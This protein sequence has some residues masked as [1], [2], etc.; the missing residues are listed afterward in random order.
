M[1]SDLT[2]I[3]EAPVS[4]ELQQHDT[5]DEEEDNICSQIREKYDDAAESTSAMRYRWENNNLTAQGKSVIG[6]VKLANQVLRIESGGD[7]RARHSY[8]N[9]TRPLIRAFTGKMIRSV[10]TYDFKPR[11]NDQ[12]DMQAS[13]I[14]KSFWDYFWDK[15]KVKVKYKRC[16]ENIPTNGTAV[17]HPYWDPDAGEDILVCDVCGY[18]HEEIDGGDPPPDM[19][20]IECPL[21][22]MKAEMMQQSQEAAGQMHPMAQQPMQEEMPEIGTLQVL[23][24]GDLR[25]L[26]HDVEDFYPDPGAEEIEPCQWIIIRSSEAVN[27][28]RTK[29]PDKAHLIEAEDDMYTDR[30]IYA[31]DGLVNG[32]VRSQRLINHVLVF[33][34]H[35]MP[36]FAYPDGRVIV[37]CNERILHISDNPIA[38]KIGRLP[39]FL[40]RGDR[41][42]KSLWGEPILDQ[43]EGT[44]REREELTT[45][46]RRAR[47]SAVSPQYVTDATSGITAGTVTNKPDAIIKVTRSGDL[48]PIKKQ[49][50]PA[51][52]PNELIRLKEAA[53]EKF[54]VTA[55]EIGAVTGDMSGRSMAFLETQ[56]SE[57][58]APLLLEINSEMLELCKTV[59]CMAQYYMDPDKIWTIKGRSQVL[60][61][62][63]GEANIKPGWDVHIAEQD[64]L[65]RNPTIRKQEAME[66]LN[67][68]NYIDR[69]TGMPDMEGFRRDAG[70]K[71]NG[72]RADADE[73][74]RIYASQFPK[75]IE[76]AMRGE[77]EMPVPKPWDNAIIFAEELYD[78][79]QTTGVSASD[80]LQATVFQMWTVYMQA[81]IETGIMAPSVAGMMPNMQLAQQGQQGQ[82]QSMG[83][84]GSEPQQQGVT[85]QTAQSVQQADNMAENQIRKA[86]PHEG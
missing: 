50:L 77:E 52:I 2:A 32:T 13:E 53:Q 68:G 19:I 75:M 82:P 26:M 37:M 18:K 84:G 57:T 70:I 1:S 36:S 42:K 48:K 86:T 6:R 63:W 3:L 7:P 66:L 51:W 35:E 62:S 4:S 20:G 31:P 80:E 65:S 30:Y 83:A 43:V 67:A 55:Q 40:I 74:Q 61:Y 54:A 10:A 17:L 24:T 28:V 44:Q 8:D 73:A 33:Y 78:W 15:E 56:S 59:I 46:I 85:T 27:V 9:I 60:S 5:P 23:K 47:K 45:D 76:K 34:Y 69:A 39:F 21:C 14:M 72:A 25:L 38:K 29:F 71:L 79:L 11:S 64:S 22:Q 12:A 16:V 81:I 49:T 41:N 58:V